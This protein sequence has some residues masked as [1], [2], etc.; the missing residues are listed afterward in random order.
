MGRHRKTESEHKRDGT[1]REDRHGDRFR[2]SSLG[3]TPKRPIGLGKHGKRFWSQW[4][5]VM[6]VGFFNAADTVSLHDAARMY[7]AW[8]ELMDDKNYHDAGKIREKFDRLAAK[9]GF[10]KL[11]RAKLPNIGQNEG[12]TLKL[13]ARKRA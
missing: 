12:Q 5:E 7:D 13:K 2:E 8:G 10:A 9:L 3:G 4:V 11:D 6:P 1:Y